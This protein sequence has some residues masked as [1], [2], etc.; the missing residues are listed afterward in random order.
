VPFTPSGQ[1]MDKAYSTVLL[2]HSSDCPKTPS[3]TCRK[4]WALIIR[5]GMHGNRLGLFYI[6]QTFQ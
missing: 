4:L 1:E 6:G 3:A 2:H 5:T